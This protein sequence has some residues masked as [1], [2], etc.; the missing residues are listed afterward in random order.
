MDG[1]YE[2]SFS[3]DENA[4]GHPIASLSGTYSAGSSVSHT[5]GATSFQASAS[6]A[7]ASTT[8]S[9]AGMFEGFPGAQF[10]GALTADSS[11]N[12]A[13]S[14]QVVCGACPDSNGNGQADRVSGT[15]DCTAI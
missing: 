9:G 1:D 6:S 3:D 15:L 11:G 10:D 13:G 2:C 12:A 8:F 4:D 14:L 5:N 7:G